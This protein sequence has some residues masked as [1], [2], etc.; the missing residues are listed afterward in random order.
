MKLLKRKGINIVTVFADPNSRRVIYVC[1]GKY[2]DTVGSFFIDLL[3]HH[4]DPGKIK[5]ACCNMSPAY[6]KGIGE[7][8]ENAQIAFDKFHVMR[9][10]NKGVDAVRRTEQKITSILKKT[11]YIWLKNPENLTAK[12][13]GSLGS[14]KDM[15][16][17]TVRAYQMKHNL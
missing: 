10:M 4:G 11:G 12:Q 1:K 7:Y 15:N 17:K 16:L 8:F 14:L 13:A 2:V 5:A 6:I 3:C 9:I